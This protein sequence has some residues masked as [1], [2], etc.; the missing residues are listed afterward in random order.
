MIVRIFTLKNGLEVLENVV[1]IRIKSKEYNLL[2][3]KDY[4][5]LLGEIEG[6]LEIE[7]E[8]EVKKFEN[9]KA[10]FMNDNN[11]FSIIFDEDIDD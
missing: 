10:S 8:N 7:L 4:V 11:C 3:L 5:S 9:I 1:A 6:E 2:I